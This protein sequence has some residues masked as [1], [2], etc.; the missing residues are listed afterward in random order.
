MDGE[1]GVKM[2][3]LKLEK[4]MAQIVSFIVHQPE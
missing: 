2:F 1:G 4:N 3:M